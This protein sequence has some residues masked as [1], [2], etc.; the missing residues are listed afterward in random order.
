MALVVIALLAYALTLASARSGCSS[1]RRAG[2]CGVTRRAMQV[3]SYAGWW[4]LLVSQ[5]LFMALFLT[6]LWRLF[7]WMRLHADASRT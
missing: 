1:V 4:R 7:L 3:V 2:R 5:P 6:W